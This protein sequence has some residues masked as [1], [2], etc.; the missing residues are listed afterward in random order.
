[1]RTQNLSGVLV[2]WEGPERLRWAHE[3]TARHSPV[4]LDDWQ[5]GDVWPNADERAEVARRITYAE[6]ILVLLSGAAPIVELPQ[7]HV[8]TVPLGVVADRVGDFVHIEIPVL[9]WLPAAL[10]AH[11]MRFAAE[12]A[13][14]IRQTPE[15]LL[16][17][18]LLD[19]DA[20]GSPVHFAYRTGHG[21]V[22]TRLLRAVIGRLL[23]HQ[24][25]PATL[26]AAC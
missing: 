15:F 5:V 7:E 10:R 18:V 19:D 12:C 24:D 13:A 6:P 25:E 2:V 22:H 16:G 8:R 23:S 17:P 14:R 4:R 20:V 1:M 11:G 26:A 21:S 3:A 9:D